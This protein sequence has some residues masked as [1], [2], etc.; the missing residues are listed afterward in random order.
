MNLS[1]LR[2]IFN[3]LVLNKIYYR[4]MTDD[5]LAQGDSLTAPDA[6]TPLTTDSNGAVEG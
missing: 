5:E 4:Q 3:G 1:Q 2:T 6:T